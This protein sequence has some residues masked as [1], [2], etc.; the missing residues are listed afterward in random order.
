MVALK[1]S[2]QPRT[3]FARIERLISVDGGEVGNECAGGAVVWQQFAPWR[4]LQQNPMPRY[5]HL[6]LLKKEYGLK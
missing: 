2:R 1:K 4:L 6:D 3:K 5:D